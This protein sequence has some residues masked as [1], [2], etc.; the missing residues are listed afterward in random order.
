MFKDFGILNLYYYFVLFYVNSLFRCSI[1]IIL[2]IISINNYNVVRMIYVF[3]YIY[4]VLK[5]CRFIF[6][7]KER[8]LNELVLFN[9]SKIIFYGIILL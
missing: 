7:L 1:K 6:I 8:M 4:I 9:L 2:K 5:G 3:F